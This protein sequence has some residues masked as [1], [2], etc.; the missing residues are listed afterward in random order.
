MT[1]SN[2]V[3]REGEKNKKST[4]IQKISTT[5]NKKT[6]RDEKQASEMES[7]VSRWTKLKKL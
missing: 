6:S 5:T 7:A 3:L 2:S 1:F 4:K